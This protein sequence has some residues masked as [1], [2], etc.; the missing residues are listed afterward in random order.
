MW[1]EKALQRAGDHSTIHHVDRVHGGSINDSY[2]VKSGENEYFIKFQT[3]A[4]ENF[5]ACEARGLSSIKMTNTI[6]VPKVFTY[7]DERPKGY[8]LLEWVV[9][10]RSNKTDQW[11]GEQL[12]QLHYCHH[13]HHGL[14]ANSFI[15]LLPQ[16]NGLY[17]SWLTYYRDKKLGGQIQYGIK[18]QTIHGKRRK[19]LNTLIDRLD[20]W[21][22]EDVPASY[23]HG[24]LW[25]G[26]WI[27]GK[28][29][30]PYL[31]DPSFLY[32]DRH[33]EI[34]FTEMFGGFSKQ[35]YEAYQSSYPLLD[36]YNDV[37]PLYQL[38]YLL[39]HLN[40]FGELY[41]A[42]VDRILEYYIGK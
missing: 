14:D 9:G 24:D 13:S 42:Q 15:G 1:V 26:N 20:E 12:A 38:Y 2:Y 32:G 17:N 16:S 29:G 8:L 39:V 35:F 10:E 4:P 41:G 36:L 22:P 40:L 31:I 19:R 23:L 27:V 34:A 25:G 7:S 30:Q 6:S 28:D 37:K 3:N 33:F 11:L 21:I 5:F 18:K